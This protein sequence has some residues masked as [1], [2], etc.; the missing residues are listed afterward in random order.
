[1]LYRWI[2]HTSELELRIEAPTEEDVFAD[3]LAAFAELA[4]RSAGSDDRRTIELEADERGL[5]LVDWLN[6]LVY[7]ADSDGF[8]PAALEELRLGDGRL[9]ATVA[10]RR[11]RPRPLV[12][13]VSLHGLRYTR[14]DDGWQA[15]VVLDV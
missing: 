10:G 7:L 14:E 8:E 11:G 9:S 5:L 3:A 15:R 2:D 12:K 1:M 13:A 6:E 4:G